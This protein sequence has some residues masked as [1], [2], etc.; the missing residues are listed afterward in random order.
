MERLEGE[1]LPV[2]GGMSRAWRQ[3]P[4]QLARGRQNLGC[5]CP[6]LPAA[7][8]KRETIRETIRGNNKRKGNNNKRTAVVHRE[9]MRR[10]CAASMSHD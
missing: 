10:K 3:G 4:Q 5:E 7:P 9:R 2:G 8:C 1:E 6:G